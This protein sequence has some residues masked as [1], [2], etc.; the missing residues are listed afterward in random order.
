MTTVQKSIRYL[1]ALIL[2]IGMALVA[3]K[4]SD[5]WPQLQSA[6]TR[7]GPDGLLIFLGSFTVLTTL[8][9]PVSV[10]G[11][12]AGLTYGPWLGLAL[13]FSAGLLSSCLIFL[14]GKS[15]FRHGVLRFVQRNPQ[16]G[17]LEKLEGHRALKIN[18]LTRLSPF[19]YGLASY[20]LAAGSSGFRAYFLGLFAMIPSMA[21][22]VWAGALA[23]EGGALLGGESS[24]SILRV[25]GI[26]V[27]VFFLALLF[28]QISRM[29]RQ[30]FREMAEESAANSD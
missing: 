11:F 26:A 5:W 2:L 28:W 14:M 4:G 9:F 1:V 20:A 23:R 25:V 16:L 22:Q 3:V 8:C 12:T 6:M 30:S 19:N 17:A 7:S 18:V 21:L 13:L 27:G 15:V 24:N 10:L 29:I